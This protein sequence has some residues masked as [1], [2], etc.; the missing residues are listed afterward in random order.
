MSDTQNPEISVVLPCYNEVD[1]ID[2]MIAQ[3]CAA[4]DSTGRTFEIVYVDDASSDG[5][6]EKL[7]QLQKT[8]PFLVPVRHKTNFGESAAF[9]TG[10]ERIR[11]SIVITM[12]ADLQNDP[13]DIPAMLRHL[14]A[15]NADAVCGIR[16]KRIDSGS[17]KI[18]SRVANGVRGWILGDGI[19]DAGCTYRVMKRA[20]IQQLPGF[21]ALHRFMPTIMKWHG[22]KVVEMEINHRART[23]GVSK[24]GIGNRLWVGIYD[25]FAMRW[26]KRRFFPPNRV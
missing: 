3:L 20:A 19:H 14:E 26:Y 5:S 16:R 24:Y 6:F 9:L 10:F 21:R 22:F 13:A 12:D 2:E 18:S 1:N 25:M 4:I 15:Q 7:Q 23:A 17:K 8:M 11:G